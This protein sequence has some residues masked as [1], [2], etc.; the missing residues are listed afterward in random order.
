LDNAVCT[1]YVLQTEEKGPSILELFA[2]AQKKYD[3]ENKVRSSTN[4]LYLNLPITNELYSCQ[5]NEKQRDK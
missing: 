1:L 5:M 2:S 3:E 4:V